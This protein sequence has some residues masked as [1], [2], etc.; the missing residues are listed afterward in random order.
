[1]KSL[2][3][4][5][6]MLCA[7]LVICSAAIAAFAEELVVGPAV[8]LG[9]E[10]FGPEISKDGLTMYYTYSRQIW[11]RTRNTLS[12]PW[13]APT[14]IP[15]S[16]YTNID[17][18][19]SADQLT[20]YYTTWSGGGYGNYDLWKATRP[21]KNSPWDNA[22]NLGSLF[23]SSDN[24]AAPDISADGLTLFYCY[25]ELPKPSPRHIWYAERPDVYSPWSA[26]RILA[27]I[28]TDNSS[29]RPSISSDGLILFFDADWPGTT[30]NC[31]WYSTRASVNDSWS[32]RIPL[33]SDGELV[34]GYYPDVSLIDDKIYFALGNYIYC[35]KILSKPELAVNKIKVILIEKADIAARIDAALDKEWE[36]YD[37]L[38]EALETGDYGGLSKRDIEKAQQNVQSAIQ[39]EEKSL[40]TLE[41][42]IEKLKHALKALGWEPEPLPE[43]ISY[44]T[45]DEGEDGI[46]YDSAGANHG[47]VVEAEWTTGQVNGALNF[48]G[49]DDY[50][51]IP[52][53]VDFNFG[54]GDFSISMWFITTGAVSS[55]GEQFMI[56]FRQNDNVP[57]IEIY[58]GYPS[59]G[60]L[61]SHLHPQ[62]ARL[63]CHSPLVEDNQWHHVAITIDNGAP[64]GFKLYLDGIKVAERTFSGALSDWDTIRIGGDSPGREEFFHGSIDE[65]MVYNQSLAPEQTQQLYWNGLI[66]Y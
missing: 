50:V 12:D 21:D 8:N 19:V 57:H 39:R 11:Y 49:V 61:G 6:I 31:L 16:T 34:Q 65:V 3:C 66:G 15:L 37:I 48:D 26:P 28:G 27:E 22:T 41:K 9:I 20:M 44:W 4:H 32:P 13:S 42:S 2:K 25:E 35:S 7:T 40:N 63:T 24:E 59:D 60:K 36:V 54:T 62:D 23:N 10:G 5:L 53:S 45:F 64:N 38:D 14:K 46:A 52:L 29:T 47:T 18:S 55:N 30:Y 56:L 1:M 58:T 51:E 33:M 17:P 43:P